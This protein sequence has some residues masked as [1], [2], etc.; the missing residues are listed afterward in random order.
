[1][2]ERNTTPANIWDA[3]RRLHNCNRQQLAARLG[4]SRAT[5]HRWETEGAG[6]AGSEKAARLMQ[7]T[8]RAADADWAPLPIDWA[9]TATIGGRR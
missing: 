3:L 6:Q 9:A 7:A 8:L 1:M 2:T 4:V 5:L